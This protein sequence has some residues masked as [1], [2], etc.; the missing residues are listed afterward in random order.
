MDL[1]EIITDVRVIVKERGLFESREM[2]LELFVWL[3]GEKLH[4]VLTFSPV[5]EKL[6][7]G[8]GWF[9]LI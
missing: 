7:N 9:C 6:G 1:E 3:V 4:V 8:C 5:G 2:M